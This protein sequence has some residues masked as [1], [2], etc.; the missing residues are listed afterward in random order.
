MIKALKVRLYPNEEQTVL[1]EKHFGA[2]RFVWNHFLEVRNKY[3]AEHKNDKKKGLSGFDTMKMLTTLK[4]E[5]TWLNEINSQ[6]LQHSLV[7]LDM[8]FKSFF[9]HN[10]S[11]PK[12][13]S[14]KDNQYFIVPSGFKVK[15][16]KLIIPKFMEGIE[17]RDES[18]IPAHIK[19]V[20]ITTLGQKSSLP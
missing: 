1:L 17:Y 5:L 20:I 2:C 16:N 8:A 7:K 12:F 13:R 11:Y 19:Q 10:T 6:S 9:K 4:K 14:K 15:E 3:Y 18:T